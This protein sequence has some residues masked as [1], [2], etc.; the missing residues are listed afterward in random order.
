MYFSTRNMPELQGL[1]ISDR[2]A[3]LHL[4]MTKLPATQKVTLNIIKIL[5]ITPIF[6]LLANIDS[7]WLLLYLLIVGVSYPII[8]TPITLFFVK[9]FISEAK[10]E[11]E[12][13]KIKGQ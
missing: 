7:W 8:T 9:P 2:Q 5:C 4:A 13:N 3:I 1:S 11:F 12:I 10:Q 6:L